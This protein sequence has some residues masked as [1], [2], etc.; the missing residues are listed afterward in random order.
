MAKIILSKSKNKEF[1]VSVTA[2]NNKKL[3]H[4][5]TFRTRQGAKNNVQALKKIIPKAK[6]V[7][8]TKPKNRK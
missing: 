1:F 3:V 2:N 7:D 8:N 6:I 4:S 5:E